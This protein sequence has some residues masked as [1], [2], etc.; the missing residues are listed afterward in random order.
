MPFV[1]RIARVLTCAAAAWAILTASPATAHPH[2]WI[3]VQT[4]VVYEK[5]AIV[6]VRHKWSFDEFYAAMAIENL[7][8]NKDGDYSREELAELA[9]VNVESL[10]E[11]DYFTVVRLAGQPV[12]LG[13]PADYWLEYVVPGPVPPTKDAKAPEP[14]GKQAGKKGTMER[15][16]GWMAGD[17]SSEG[18]DKSGAPAKVLSLHFY[19]PLEKPILAEAEGFSFEVS[20]PT[21][22]IAFT[23]AQHDPVTL[24][25]A[26]P[27]C[28]VVP[29]APTADDDRTLGATSIATPEGMAFITPKVIN[30]SCKAER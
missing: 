6:G 22:F 27:E 12:K 13:A 8:K 11:Y 21:Y 9:K 17:K 30:I 18:T 3:T 2:V 14:A 26:P 10:K 16:W 29:S 20:D 4:T 28:H 25:G 23:Y 5:G 19:L 7:D 15:F 24:Q 1:M